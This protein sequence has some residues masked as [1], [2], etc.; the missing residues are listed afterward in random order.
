MRLQLSKNMKRQ[1]MADPKMNETVLTAF[2]ET[3]GGSD[4][5]ECYFAP[6]RVNLIGEH[7]DYNGGHVFPCALT[8]GTYLAV[9]K[10][11]GD[12]LR[13]CSVNFPDAGPEEC[14]LSDV[15]PGTDNSWTSYVKGVIWAAGQYLS[16]RS[17]GSD[18][19][20]IDC[21]MDIM[22]GG[23]IPEGAGLSSSASLEV[24]TGYM[25]SDQFGLGLSGKDLALIGQHAENMYVGVNCGIMDQFASAMGRED[26]AIYLDTS[27]LE[28]EY[29]P[30]SLGD[31]ALV[32]TNTNKPHSL[33]DSAYNDRRKEC[34]DALEILK[35]VCDAEAL[36]EITTEEFEAHK[37][38]LTDPILL[39]RA[40]HAVTEDRRV[41]DAVKVLQNGD[42]QAF[43]ALMNGSHISLRDDY[44]VSCPELDLLAETA[45]TI[46]GV[47][48]SRMTGGGFGGCTV[49]IIDKDQVEEYKRIVGARYRERFGYDCTFIVAAAGGGPNKTA[50]THSA[51]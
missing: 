33:N 51:G 6:G 49:S 8:F 36:C 45:W 2:D 26:H 28:Y 5:A 47:L 10:R 50:V 1:K 42:L 27:S 7:T 22:I 19:P 44:E 39:K 14:S 25:L 9:R 38:V 18:A 32:I 12:T 23:D 48:G 20:V 30:L 29:V 3:Y 15:Q 16:G 40:R 21:G 46:P 37:E 24:V 43:G 11:S 34:S 17:G 31:H 13:I 41:K 4:R 35:T